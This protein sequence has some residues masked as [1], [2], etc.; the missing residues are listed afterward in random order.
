[1]NTN[2]C[3]ICRQSVIEVQGRYGTYLANASVQYANGARYNR[4]AH[5]C[6]PGVAEAAEQRRVEEDA[7]LAAVMAADDFDDFGGIAD[8]DH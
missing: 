8:W 7:Y 3:P 5:H 6:P 4:G 2:Q 1:M